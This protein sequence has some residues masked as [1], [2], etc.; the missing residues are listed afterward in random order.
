MYIKNTLRE[1]ITTGELLTI[2]YHGG[3]QPGSTRMISPIKVEGDKVRARCYTSNRIKVF[4][5]AKI[6]LT[7]SSP[8]NTSYV[9]GKKPEEPNSVIDAFKPY[10]VDLESM[11]WHVKLEDDSIGLFR[12]FKN[13]KFRKTAD[14]RCLRH[15]FTSDLVDI[16]DGRMGYHE[17]SLSRPYYV[18]STQS[19]RNGISYKY[20]SKAVIL[21]LD[22]AKDGANKFSIPLS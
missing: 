21:F 8:G 20:L 12:Y 14:I 16:E 3:S 15:K 19:G 4:I 18:Y 10:V 1:A 17:K 5:I 13:G 9:E 2:I 11:G 22:Y 6:E 7:E